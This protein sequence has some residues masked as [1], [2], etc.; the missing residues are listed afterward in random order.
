MSPHKPDS[1]LHEIL[2]ALPTRPAPRT[3]ETRVRAEL[4]RLEARPWWRR[5]Y[6]AWP[7]WL[8]GAFLAVT[9]VVAVA[10]AVGPSRVLYELAGHL[11]WLASLLSLGEG[12]AGTVRDILHAIPTAWLY[13]ALAAVATC[14]AVLAGLGALAY[15]AFFR[16]KLHLSHRPSA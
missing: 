6:R 11:E 5:S 7:Q 13:G 9:A 1:R 4:A 10:V 12:L 16:A 2:R 15:R 14:Y 8:R 3:L